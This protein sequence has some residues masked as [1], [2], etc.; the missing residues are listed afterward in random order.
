MA[1]F[2]QLKTGAVAQYP[3]SRSIEQ[4]TRVLRFIDGTEQRFRQTG[5]E[6]RRWVIRLELLEDDELARLAD[7]F[8][9]QRG[10]D[11]DFRFVD[12]ADGTAY[13]SC[14][15]DHDECRLDLVEEGRSKSVVVV[16]EN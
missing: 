11:G 12:P 7:F 15:F 4:R 3:L 6:L 5:R 9:A 16:K 10:R 13:P 1:D 2:P 8:A 14:S